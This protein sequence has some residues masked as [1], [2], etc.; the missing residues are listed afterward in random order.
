M[1]TE[2]ISKLKAMLA[3]E[4]SARQIYKDGLDSIKELDGLSKSAKELEAAI[5]R[6]EGEKAKHDKRADAARENAKRI[7][8]DYAAYAIEAKQRIDSDLAQAQRHIEALTVEARDEVKALQSKSKALSAQ[9]KDKEA[10]AAK[11]EADLIKAEAELEKIRGKLK[12]I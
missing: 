9:I 12:S 1:K 11:A 10:K 7:E 5:K 4:V 2:N 6:L 3:H 8:D